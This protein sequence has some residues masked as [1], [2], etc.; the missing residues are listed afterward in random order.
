MMPKL[1]LAG[2]E[3]GIGMLAPNVLLRQLAIVL[4]TLDIMLVAP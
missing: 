1:S 3:I 2:I 4:V